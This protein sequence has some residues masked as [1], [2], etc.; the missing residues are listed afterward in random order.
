MVMVAKKFPLL[1]IGMGRTQILEELTV[2]EVIFDKG[3]VV[4]HDTL[5][6]VGTAGIGY[7][8]LSTHEHAYVGANVFYDYAFKDKFSRVSAGLEYVAGLN[9]ISVNVYHGLSEKKGGTL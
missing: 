8:R 5:G 4:E 2:K 7:R 6:V 3:E 1:H 9:T